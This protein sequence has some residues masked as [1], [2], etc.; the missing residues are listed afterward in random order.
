MSEV[1]DERSACILRCK[2]NIV[3]ED[4]GRILLRNAYI[5]RSTLLRTSH[6]LE[7]CK[8]QRVTSDV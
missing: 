2:L 1:Y 3:P 8:S 5:H 7:N 4:G 6:C